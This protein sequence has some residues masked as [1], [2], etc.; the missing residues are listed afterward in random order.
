[1]DNG[2]DETDVFKGQNKGA[3]LVSFF[4]H[5]FLRSNSLTQFKSV[6]HLFGYYLFLTAIILIEAIW[7]V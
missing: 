5:N 7:N 3:I 1:M 6:S 2:Q 4:V